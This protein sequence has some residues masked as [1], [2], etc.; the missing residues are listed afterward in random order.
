[1]AGGDRSVLEAILQKADLLSFCGKTLPFFT[2]SHKMGWRGSLKIVQ[3][4][5]DFS[6]LDESETAILP[7]WNK[8]LEST[9]NVVWYELKYKVEIIRELNLKFPRSSVFPQS[10]SGLCEPAS[11]MRRANDGDNGENHPAFGAGKMI[12]SGSKLPITAAVFQ[13]RC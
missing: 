12:L 8:C 13:R 2:P 3:N 9:L 5:K 11:P 10:Q 6:R 4:L 1:M 7:I